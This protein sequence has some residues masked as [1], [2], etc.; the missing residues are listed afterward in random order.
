[1][2]SGRSRRFNRSNTCSFLAWR[3][4]MSSNACRMGW[5]ATSSSAARMLANGSRSTR[6][7]RSSSCASP[8]TSTALSSTKY[9][10]APTTCGCGSALR[11]S[12]SMF[13]RIASRARVPAD[14]GAGLSQ[15]G[16]RHARRHPQDGC[17]SAECKIGG[18]VMKTWFSDIY[19]DIDAMRLDRFALEIDRQIGE[20]S[21]YG[22]SGQATSSPGPRSFWSIDR[23]G[24]E[25]N[26]HSRVWKS[27]CSQA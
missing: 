2:A 6:K 9:S 13:H 5:C 23:D 14:H 10:A 26:R 17:R 21:D 16:R 3:N 1:M 8:A 11:C 25:G 18:G 27:E 22:V 12:F 20:R 7:R 15:D 24:N 4:A 19:A